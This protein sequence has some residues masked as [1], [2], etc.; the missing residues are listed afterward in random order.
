MVY[1]ISLS[2]DHPMKFAVNDVTNRYQ[3]VQDFATINSMLHRASKLARFVGSREAVIWILVPYHLIIHI[4]K[5]LELRTR[6]VFVSLYRHHE[7]WISMDTDAY[8]WISLCPKMAC[9]QIQWLI[10][11]HVLH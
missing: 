3:L 4:L 8:G 5:C 1:P 9:T 6:E 11:H 7:G 10:N 2:H